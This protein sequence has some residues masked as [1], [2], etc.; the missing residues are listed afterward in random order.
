MTMTVG[1]G[2]FGHAPGGRF[3]FDVP[4]DGVEYLES[5]PRRIR[6]ELGGDVV[7]DSLGVRLLHR[8]HHLPVWCFP[9]EDVQAGRLGDG[10]WTYDSGLAEGLVGVRWDAVDR[11]LEEGEEVIVHPRDPYHRLE[12]RDS[13]RDVRI[14]LQAELLAESS[15]ALALFETGLPAR[16][17]LPRDDVTVGLGANDWLRTGCAYKG[18][19]GYFDATLADGREEPFLVWR[20][21]DPL[22]EVTR[23][24]DRLCF[25]NER[26]DVLLDGVTQE[27]PR[28][29][30]SGTDWARDPKPP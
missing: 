30:W 4:G 5:F 15:R 29:Q 14:E 1:S 7:V 20:Y 12:L 2:P 13:S 6:A 10:A 25:F 27:L 19:A 8:Q 26:V 22:A 28:T 23:I 11:W 16:W 21:T 24:K 9:A 17:C 3:N 18:Y